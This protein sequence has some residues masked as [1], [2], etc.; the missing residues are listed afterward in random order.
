MN[1]EVIQKCPAFFIHVPELSEARKAD[2]ITNK[3]KEAGYKN[4]Q[5][6]RGINGKNEDEVQQAKQKIGI[7]KFDRYCGNSNIGCNLSML[8]VFK[9]MIEK[10]IMIAS[11]FEDDVLFHP[12]WDKLAPMFYAHTPKKFDIIYMGN[13]VEQ[14][15]NVNNI[16]AVHHKST[17]CMHGLIVSLHGAKRMLNLITGWDCNSNYATQCMGRP[18]TGTTNCDIIL[19]NVQDRIL[20]NELKPD[21]LVWYCWNGTNC[22]CPYNALPLNENHRQRNTGLVFQ[23]SAIPSTT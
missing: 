9:T 7:N 3:L 13:Q 16:P 23:N 2:D 10:N 20:N 5:M 19:K 1:F 12:E 15:Y 14:C 4:I 17:F 6:F 11:I 18:A 22:K 21:L 8:S